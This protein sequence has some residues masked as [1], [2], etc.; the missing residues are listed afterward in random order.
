M[1]AS[2]SSGEGDAP[3]LVSQAPI[4][5]SSATLSIQARIVQLSK[6]APPL[7]PNAWVYCADDLAPSSVLSTY[8]GP[9]FEQRRG[10]PCRITFKNALAAQGNLLPVPPGVNPLGASLCGNVRRQS[11]VGL[12]V[13]LHGARAQGF[14]PDADTDHDG[15]PLTP[16][17]IE[18]N[19]F[20]FPASQTHLYPNDQRA[21]LLWYHDHGLDHTSTHVHAGLVGLYFIRDANDDAILD[22]VGGTAQELVY[23]IQDRIL[24]SDGKHFDYDAGTP[25]QS[26]FQRPEYLGDRL[27]L[28]GQLA[29]TAT[30]NPQAWRW[31]ML[32]GCNART[33]A[34]ALCDMDAV[35]AGSG[36]VWHTNCL[37]LIGNDG[38]LLGRSVALGATDTL[39]IAPGQRR[40][41]LL[42]L[43]QLPAGVKRLRLVNVAL[44]YH[45][46]A[47][48][49]TPEA[50]YTT[51]G[52]SVLAPSRAD[53]TKDDNSLYGALGHTLAVVQ[54]I[55]VS[56]VSIQQKTQL[57]LQTPQAVAIDQILSNAATDVDFAW[58]GSEL[59][60]EQGAQLGPNR[61]VL[62][63]SNTAGYDAAA[64]PA[65]TQNYPGW[66]DV[67]IF[68]LTAG[69]GSGLQWT[70]PFSVDL[71]STSNPAA[72][73]AST[74]Q[75]SYTVS[76]STFFESSSVA[77]ITQARAYPALHTP[78]IQA[79]AG[80]Y[81]RW[82]VA[83]LGNSQPL[84]SLTDMP[85]MHPFH[86]HLVTFVVQRRW[87]LVG[88]TFELDTPDALDGI[89]RQDTIIIPSNAMVELL[90]YY[91][92]GYT[93]NYTYHCHLLEHEDQCMMSHF[94]VS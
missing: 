13:H 80:S 21:S 44:A 9:T 37:R 54:D 89:A 66:S 6:A 79:R 76:R 78:T 52:N 61:F 83:N 85:D 65:S 34:L 33:I 40:D 31:R 72:A 22:A 8:L 2:C 92:T 17:G 4:R 59:V 42:D 58:N 36:R 84:N 16:L 48:D 24:S 71:S 1:L 32:N 82:Y 15:W 81:E 5:T 7:T 67:Q 27:L 25:N 94:L 88:G 12:A 49:T 69:G 46:L 62:L 18:K 28:N 14:T 64:D 35:A 90:V 56:A 91:P 3:A 20:G 93:G 11:D 87:K 23:V 73:G 68:E 51:Y 60:A 30:L 57:A 86:I 19:P 50:I 55:N 29:A 70:V 74:S 10:V 38:G 63:L 26:D 43:S 77:D 45:L 53:Y 75:V 41:V 47:D 39:V